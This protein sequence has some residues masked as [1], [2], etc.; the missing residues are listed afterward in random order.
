MLNSYTYDAFGNTLSYA[1]KVSN[2]FMYAGEQFDKLTGQYYLRARHY[3]P[4]I[5][6]FIQEDSYRGRI[7]DPLSLH[8]YTYCHNNPIKYID[9]SGHSPV[10]YDTD[11][12]YDPSAGSGGSHDNGIGEYK[13]E[14]CED[15]KGT[16]KPTTTHTPKDNLYNS[17]KE[18]A[19]A[20][21]NT[22]NTESGSEN[23]EYFAYIVKTDSGKYTFTQVQNSKKGKYQWSP[24]G[25][26]YGTEGQTAVAGIHSHA[27]FRPG[28]GD[29]DLRFSNEDK[30]W[31]SRGLPLY[32]SNAAGELLLYKDNVMN[33]ENPRVENGQIYL[34]ATGLPRQKNV[35]ENLTGYHPYIYKEVKP[36]WKNLPWN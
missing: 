20:F 21:A 23:V 14:K 22:Y 15:T 17:E 1:E 8:L 12:S 5:G 6:R 30:S 11:S 2:R 29:S 33:V 16:G 7:T 34:V 32:L 27:T 18:A 36:W 35:P 31:A 9:P 24:E 19:I 28:F 10:N 25:Y 3:Q 4:G 26:K 13:N